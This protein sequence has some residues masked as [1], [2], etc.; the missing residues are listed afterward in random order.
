MDHLFTYR[1]DPELLTYYC[2]AYLIKSKGALTQI[3]ST[4][5][6]HNF[7][8]TQTGVAFKNIKEAAVK[9]HQKY[10]QKVFAGTISNN[11]PLIKDG[12]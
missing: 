1:E 2:A 8:Q 9:L 3:F 6:L 4:E 7:Q 12:S 11:I 5:E 10:S